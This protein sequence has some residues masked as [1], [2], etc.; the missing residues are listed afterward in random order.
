M[1]TLCSASASNLN[2]KRRSRQRKEK[3][4]KVK[5]KWVALLRRRRLLWRR[6]R[7]RRSLPARHTLCDSDQPSGTRPAQMSW[8]PPVSHAAEGRGL[9]CGGHPQHRLPNPQSHRLKRKNVPLCFVFFDWKQFSN[10]IK[11][12]SFPA[13]L[14]R[15]KHTCRKIVSKKLISFANVALAIT[16]LA[17]CIPVAD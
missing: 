5:D 15:K 6:R 16:K 12:T 14:R 1:R 7:G 3:R 11:A 9:V 13:A 10:N 17:N 2:E 8:A 4:E